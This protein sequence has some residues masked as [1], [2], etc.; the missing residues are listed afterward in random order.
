MTSSRPLAW[1]KI[2]LWCYFALILLEGVL[3]KWVL[4]QYSDV[5]FVARDPVV[6]VVYALAWRAGAL[7]WGAALAG[8]WLL[9]LSSL[10]LAF[11]TENP[12]IVTLFGLRTNYLHLPLIY[13]LAEALDRADV[14]RFGIVCL[15]C[16]VPVTALMFVQYN[17][18]PDAF[19]NVGVGRQE[20]GQIIGALGRI[21]PPGPFSFIG[22][23]V[24]FFALT[25]AFV[26]DGW[27]HPGRVPR[28]LLVAAT[29]ALAVALPISI[30]RTLTAVLLVGGVFGFATV[31]HDF[32][33]IP[34]YAGA[35][36]VVVVVLLVAANFGFLEAFNKRWIEATDSRDGTIQGNL[37]ARIFGDFIQASEVAASVPWGGHG[38]GLGTV[39]GAQL[40]SGRNAFLL[41]ES[42]W[43]RVVLELGPLL[44]FAFLAW[45]TWLAF[46]LVARSWRHFQFTG[47]PLAWTLAGASFLPIL[48]GQWG[49]STHLG[50][51]V[52]G[53]GLCLAALNN[54]ADPDDVAEE[55]GATAA[56]DT[57][58]P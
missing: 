23:L 38:I 53:A 14:R 21:R 1:L 29:I 22:G 10:L 35:L 16:S 51:A 39:A 55:D 25:A 42:E 28:W 4:P 43:T 11:T 41:A 17:S 45:R 24:A 56:P 20:N 44:G 47:D 9:A 5:L 32:R 34:R 52:F 54:P 37:T 12:F 3:R 57:A 6:L 50:F 19:V 31:V 33:R 15:V 26:F 40:A 13:V 58:G 48:N 46:A 49:P 7:R 18:P 36:S 30:S 2:S 27:L 8:I